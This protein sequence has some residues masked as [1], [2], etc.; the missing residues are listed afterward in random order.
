M[1]AVHAGG[2]AVEVRWWDRYRVL[3][4]AVAGH[5][6]SGT[7]GRSNGIVR[8]LRTLDASVAAVNQ[9]GR[10]K[11]AVNVALSTLTL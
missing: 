1:P 10:R 9:G 11:G 8:W 5:A 3:P 2:T 6:D 7:N 4:G